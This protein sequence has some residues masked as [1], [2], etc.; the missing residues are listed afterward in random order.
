M[1]TTNYEISKQLAEAGLEAECAYL[2]FEKD[3]AI[4]IGDWIHPIN[5]IE[6]INKEAISYLP[7]NN[8]SYPAYDLERILE[9]LPNF[10]A[11]KNKGENCLVIDVA[12]GEI[13]YL[14]RHPSLFCS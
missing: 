3:Q 2:W 7:K 6:K 1:K 14:E 5:K 4:K 10:I 12:F 11:N 13:H 9:A 8:K